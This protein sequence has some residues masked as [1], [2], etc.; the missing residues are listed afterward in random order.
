MIVENTPIDTISLTELLD[1]VRVGLEAM[2][3]RLREVSRDQHNMLTVAIEHLLDSG[4]KRVRPA[5]ALLSSQ[6]F[7]GDFKYAVALASAVEMLH[8]ATLVHDDLIDGSLLRRGIPTLNAN[9]SPDSTV[10]TG[11]YLF[12]RAANFASQTDSVR[13][14]N[15]FSETLMVIVNGEIKQK[16]S[17]AGRMSRNDYYGRIQAKTASMFALA[18][19]AGAVLGHASE[20]EIRAMRLFGREVGM[21]F[22]IVDDVLDFVGSSDH[23]GKPVGS[24]LQQGLFTLPALRYLEANP[25]DPVAQDVFNGHKTDQETV[26]QV[27]SAVRDSGAVKDAMDEAR[28]YARN[29]QR[30]LDGLPNGEYLQSLFVM[31]DYIV[32]RDM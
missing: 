23:I 15:L 8:T 2:E 27:V 20:V 9:W 7:N 5:V 6:M 22:Q 19:E 16:F 12:A 14:M 10:L 28:A 3:T 29:G 21:A 25:D 30:A 17:T 31:A 24:D 1:P 11:D 4:G 13:V 18:A 32:A 26:L